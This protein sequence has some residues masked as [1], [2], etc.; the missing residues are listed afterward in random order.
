M[1]LAIIASHLEKNRGS[2]PADRKTLKEHIVLKAKQAGLSLP[3][4]EVRE[5]VARFCK[6]QNEADNDVKKDGMTIG[7]T[8]NL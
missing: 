1:R 6:P 5:L 7:S 4:S 8:E 2:L 3:D